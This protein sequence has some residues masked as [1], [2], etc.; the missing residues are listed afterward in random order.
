MKKKT[1]LIIAGVI[2]VLLLVTGFV[3]YK[4]VF[5]GSPTSTQTT[6]DITPIE[7]PAA[8]SSIQVNLTE[9]KTAANTVIISV[10][11]LGSKISTIAYE[12]TYESN[13]LIK[14]V[15]SGSKPAEVA[16]KDSFERDIY[17]GTCSR[18]V[19]KP[20]TGVSKITLNL[21][22]TDTTGKQSQFSK[23]YTL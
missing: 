18:N 12:L 10:K 21:V 22:F 8:D 4:A 14:G 2:V 23:D 6:E 17:L 11:G 19:C 5:S 16:G 3:V 9:S 7:L 20:D 13:G 15:N 1:G